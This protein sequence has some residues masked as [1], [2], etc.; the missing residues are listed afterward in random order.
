MKMTSHS[1]QPTNEVT[2]ME[3]ARLQ[4]WSRSYVTQLKHDGR[5]VM[6]GRRVLVTES[7]ARIKA[8]SDP[9]RDDVKQRHAT[10]REQE[11]LDDEMSTAN[12]A[13]YQDARARKEVALADIAEANRDE[14]LGLLVLADEVKKA[15]ADLGTM[16]RTAMER[17]QDQLS[18]EIAPETDPDR[19]HALLGKHIEITLNEISRG[20]NQLLEGEA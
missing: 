19:V 9:N 7:V 12:R 3:F 1:E 20:L 8:T 15:G 16:L 17:M 2:Q 11:A 14:A 5:L 18:V 10:E 13:D 6:S 4:R